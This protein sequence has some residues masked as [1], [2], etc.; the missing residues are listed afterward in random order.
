MQTFAK[1]F[2]PRDYGKKITKITV[3][4]EITDCTGEV[5]VTD[6]MFQSGEIATL[7][8]GH[9]SEIRWSLDA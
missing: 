5:K 9:P 7:W 1:T 6:I 4:L 3:E 8:V 2:D